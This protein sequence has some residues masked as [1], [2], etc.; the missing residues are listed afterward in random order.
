MA[1][2]LPTLSVPSPS[3]PEPAPAVVAAASF[4][5]LPVELRLEVY[6]Y[7]LVDPYNAASRAVPPRPAAATLTASSETTTAQQQPPSPSQQTTTSTTAAAAAAT[8]IT[9]T[10]TPTK[11]TTTSFP[12]PHATAILRTSHQ[13]H[14]EATP[15]LYKSH[16]FLAHP[17]SLL[18]HF[19]RL[20]PSHRPIQHAE[21]SPLLRSLI[22]R[23]K[24]HLRLDVDPK[25][26]ARDAARH[27]SAK[28]ELVLEVS[29]ACWR[30]V[31]PDHLRLFER[32]RGVKRARVVG[33]VGGF[34]GYAAWLEDSMMA[35]RG[36]EWSGM[37]GSWSWGL[38]ILLL[39]VM[40]M[41]MMMMM[42]ML[43]LH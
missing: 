39:V 1:A 25:F 13:I 3:A 38:I 40:V 9:T 18:T 16:I 42:M 34:E 8:T 14:T 22:T 35:P 23:Y 28:D 11:R 17:G 21:H 7:L 24:L 15:I 43:L 26:T 2:V 6:R 5:G 32:V 31:G 41:M 19:P 36:G 10:T 12:A 37:T 4:L 20:S 29:Q 27:F 30:G 33:S